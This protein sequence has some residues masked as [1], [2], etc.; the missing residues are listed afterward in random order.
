[1]EIAIQQ[2][3]PVNIQLQIEVEPEAVN[4]AFERALRTL[5]KA[6]RVPGF[7]PGQAPLAVLRQHLADEMVRRAARELLIEESLTTALRQHN[8]EPYTA[9]QVEIEQFQE[10]EPFR[11]KALVSLPPQVEIGEY[12]D[13][14]IER[15]PQEAT[16]EEVEQSLE[17]IQEQLLELRRTSDRPAQLKDRLV[18]RLRSLEEENAQPSRYM[19]ILGESFGELDN[20]LVGMQE[21]ETRIATLTFPEDFSDA[22]LAGKTKQVEITLEQIHAPH[23]PPLDDTLAQRFGMETLDALRRHIR[24]RIVADK[25]ER[26]TDRVEME[27]LTILRQRCTVH[28]PQTLIQR[29]TEEEIRDLV[30]RLA[31]RGITLQTFL[32]EANMSREQLTEMLM[33]RAITKL[34]N[35]FILQEI[36]RREGIEVSSEEVQE[37]LRIAAQQMATLPAE[38]ARLMNDPELANRIRNELLLE[39]TLQK[40]VEIVQNREGETTTP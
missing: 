37:V 2:L 35:T 28:L 22:T 39:R 19:V 4:R 30:E 10:G 17:S 13:I 14:R 25:E 1:M 20:T 24:E 34:Q 9:P 27:L 40:L 7:R 36:A 31:E 6:V 12:R 8:L 5:G 23:L 18:I 33:Q 15:T 29:Q 21:G 26:E 3:D 11:Y 38:R 32:Q 16:D